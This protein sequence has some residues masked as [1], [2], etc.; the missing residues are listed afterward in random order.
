MDNLR[1]QQT[2]PR[3]MMFR[4]I[5]GKESLTEPP[6][7]FRTAESL[8]KVGSIFQ[9]FKL[10]FGIR[11]VITGVRPAVRLGYPK[12]R[13]QQRHRLRLH[14]RTPV[15]Q[16]AARPGPPGVPGHSGPVEEMDVS[17]A[18]AEAYSF[19]NG[20]D[21]H[22]P[23]RPQSLHKPAWCRVQGELLKQFNL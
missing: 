15:G 4:V 3:M 1:S 5:P 22:W 23:G 7:I 17:A 14:G 19:S 11:V 6:G 13:K 12:V 18:R 2:D 9:G 8:R 21:T 20:A 10:G 16:S